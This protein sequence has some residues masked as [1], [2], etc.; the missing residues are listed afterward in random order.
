MLVMRFGSRTGST[1][2]I[3]AAIYRKCVFNQSELAI[4]GHPTRVCPALDTIDATQIG[5]FEQAD[6]RSDNHS[7]QDSVRQILEQLRSE[8]QQKCDGNRTHDSGQLCL[9]TRRFSHWCAR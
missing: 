9:G 5:Q 4:K 6:G 7:C 2:L 1:Q 8:D 3:N